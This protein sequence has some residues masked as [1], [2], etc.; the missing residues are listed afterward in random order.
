MHRRESIFLHWW[1]NFILSFIL[2]QN[3]LKI[4]LR[5]LEQNDWH[6]MLITADTLIWKEK[7]RF[8]SCSKTEKCNFQIQFLLI[9]LSPFIPDRVFSLGTVVR[10]SFNSQW[11]RVQFSRVLHK[12]GPCVRLSVEQCLYIYE[13]ICFWFV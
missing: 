2:R 5:I 7:K 11:Q 3:S 4:S 8:K 1:Q 6:F 9:D 13:A 12:Y 10:A